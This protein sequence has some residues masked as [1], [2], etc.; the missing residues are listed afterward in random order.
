MVNPMI[1]FLA[2]GRINI[3][4]A[5]DHKPRP[6]MS[7][8]KFPTKARLQLVSQTNHATIITITKKFLVSQVEWGQ[9]LSDLAR[10]I[11]CELKKQPEGAKII[12]NALNSIKEQDSE[13]QILLGFFCQY[14]IGTQLN[15][16]K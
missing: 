2:L 6:R 15:Y 7:D 14:A 4:T 12:F 10:E 13:T 3:K 5:H 11:I 9:Y 16:P 1:P 8:S